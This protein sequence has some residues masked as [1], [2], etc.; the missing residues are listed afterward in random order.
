[1]KTN[2]QVRGHKLPSLKSTTTNL[3]SLPRKRSSSKVHEHVTNAFHI[4]AAALLDTEVIV[5]A[6]IT[7]CTCQILAFAI[8]HMLPRLW[9]AE[10]FRQTKVNDVKKIRPSPTTY[11]EVILVW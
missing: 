4:V 11:K 6:C 3:E 10:P 7:W 2:D 1:M 8:R 9:M 5:D